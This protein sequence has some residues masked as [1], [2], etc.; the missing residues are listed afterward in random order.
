MGVWVG[1]CLCET[2]Y[3]CPLMNGVMEASKSDQRVSSDAQKRC[4]CGCG[5]VGG[6]G[7]VQYLPEFIF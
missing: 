6:D 2:Q 5:C 7:T 4:V 3:P 1:G